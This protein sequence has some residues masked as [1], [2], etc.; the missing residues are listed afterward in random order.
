M[1]YY[2]QTN[3][4]STSWLLDIP[5]PIEILNSVK[6][7]VNGDQGTN[8]SVACFSDANP[9]P[10]YTWIRLDRIGGLIQEVR[11]A[12]NLSG[13]LRLNNVQINATGDY[14]CTAQNKPDPE[15]KQKQY[16]TSK[17]I[18]IKINCT[19]YYLIN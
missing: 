12:E 9:V 11:L 1:V 16:S 17:T 3:L 6:D 13:E 4:Y 10:K 7:V 14:K 18:A 2:I 5:D 15:R 8:L 19:C